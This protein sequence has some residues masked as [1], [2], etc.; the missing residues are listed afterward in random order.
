MVRGKDMTEKK[1]E[2]HM[3]YDANYNKKLEPE[4]DSLQYIQTH[5]GV[6]YR[7]MRVE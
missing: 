5:I 2:S 6:G 3:L 4:S 1:M 7:M